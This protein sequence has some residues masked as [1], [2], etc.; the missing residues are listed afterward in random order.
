MLAP[1][2][3]V[4][5]WRR[6][7]AEY[8]DAATYSNSHVV[9]GPILQPGETLTTIWLGWYAQHV[10]RNKG[11]GIGM[12]VALGVIVGPLSWTAVDVPDPYADPNA[13]WV[14]YDSGFYMPQLLSSPE[15]VT[16]EVDVYP[17][18]NSEKVKI[19][20]QR[21]AP[22]GGG[23]V[24]FRASTSSLSPEQSRFYLCLTYS[25]GVLAAP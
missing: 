22:E 20:A 17:V 14:W 8:A 23:Y 3:R 18:D 2:A 1:M 19:K 10:S 9:Q 6:G 25:C 21:K 5:Q 4:M 12:G 24:W 11:D 13:D 16:D 15:G 7:N